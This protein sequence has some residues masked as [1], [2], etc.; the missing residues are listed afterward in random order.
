MSQS[1]TTNMNPDFFL[2]DF[3][4]TTK[5]FEDLTRKVSTGH[6]PFSTTLV[7][8][9]DDLNVEPLKLPL[10]PEEES[11]I[12]KHM[13]KA[14]QEQLAKIGDHFIAAKKK[15]MSTGARVKEW[16]GDF[17]D[18]VKAGF[19]GL[20]EMAILSVTTPFEK[21]PVTKARKAELLQDK[22]PKL[23]K[24]LVA[25]EEFCN[26]V[27]QKYEQAKE[28]LSE[29]KH[30]AG[31]KINNAK[32]A[33]GKAMGKFTDKF[34]KKGSYKLE[35]VKTG[36]NSRSPSFRENVTKSRSGSLVGKGIA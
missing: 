30:S 36:E 33:V 9:I 14:A 26:A 24:C 6:I 23:H 17:K 29:F 19:E 8:D 16:A 32:N 12:Q 5:A 13:P 10:L 35:Q 34:R 11:L 15:L 21:R 1:L 22:Y 7:D 20:K 25:V 3:E 27:K 28:K 31:E 4:P 18:R 2:T